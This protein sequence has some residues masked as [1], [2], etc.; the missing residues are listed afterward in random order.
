[1]T[2]VLIN[3]FDGGI[4]EDKYAKNSNQAALIKHFDIYAS[5]NRL[6]PV[7]ALVTDTDGQHEIGN[8]IAGSDGKLFGLG[9][10]VDNPSTDPGRIFSKA[11][12]ASAWATL[13]NSDHGYAVDYR[14]FMEYKD[15]LFTANQSRY[16]GRHKRDGTA[17]GSDTYWD[18]TAYTNICNPIVH[19]K[20]DIMYVGFDNK[21]GINN[22]GSTSIITTLIPSSLKITSLSWYGD[23]L[24][25]ACSP[26]SA[27]GVGNA[28]MRSTVYLW[29]RDTSLATLTESIDFGTGEIGILNNLDNVLIAVMQLGGSSANV[30]D[31]DAIQVKGYAG[32]AP[33]L[34]RELST[35][36]E[37]TTH[38]YAQ[39][40]PR[41]DFIYRGR[42]YFS[43]SLVGGSSSPEVYGLFSLGRSKA[44]GEYA[45]TVERSA[46]AS[47]IAAAAAGDF[48]AT[49]EGT[50]GTVKT[51]TSSTSLTSAFTTT[52]LYESL[53]NPGMSTGDQP[54]LKRLIS[55]TVTYE[56]LIASRTVSLEYKV[57]G[58]SWIAVKTSIASTD[59]ITGYGATNESSGDLFEQGREFQ[60]RVS[61]DGGAVITGLNYEYEVADRNL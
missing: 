19:P 14:V 51:S 57:D 38:P 7:R 30:L 21:I 11:T 5:P 46:S 60:F 34:I 44:T 48:F 3:R 36:R 37:T 6:T 59:G 27:S 50:V 28:S 52:S 9:T 4:A 54:R 16:L 58:G 45:V 31:R 8:L 2:H 33:F 23:Y 56:R 15:F 32:G 18:L 24:A 49:V 29:N 41:V 43:V 1:M 47:V 42:M 61:S 10:N 20:D 26:V 12:P 39:V 55:I 17:G 53:V 40:N 25:I 22:N 35:I 13:G